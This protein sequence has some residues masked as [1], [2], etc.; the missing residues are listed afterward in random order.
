M[1]SAVDLLSHEKLRKET[2]S[3]L[4][5]TST[6]SLTS[7]S[8]FPSE[9]DHV[10]QEQHQQP[11]YE[12]SE[13][14][15]DVS[16]STPDLVEEE[17]EVPLEYPDECAFQ[18]NPLYFDQS[19]LQQD[20]Q[21]KKFLYRID[22]DEEIIAIQLEKQRALQ[23]ILDI[24][25]SAL[26]S[27][28]PSSSSPS[29]FTASATP[30][31]RDLQNALET[32]YLFRQSAIA[33]YAD[34]EDV[35]EDEH[36]VLLDAIAQATLH[37][38][39]KARERKIDTL[40]YNLHSS[41]DAV[42]SVAN[43]DSLASKTQT[44]TWRRRRAS[45]RI[46]SQDLEDYMD[47]IHMSVSD[48]D[49]LLE[50]MGVAVPPFNNPNGLDQ[51]E[52]PT[53]P[54]TPVTSAAVFSSNEEGENAPALSFSR[55][56]FGLAINTSTPSPVPEIFSALPSAPLTAATSTYS[57]LDD[58]LSDN[59]SLFGL[60]DQK[61]AA[62]RKRHSQHSKGTKALKW[63]GVTPKEEA[64]M[65]R[66]SM[67][68]SI[69]GSMTPIASL[70]RPHLQPERSSM[71]SAIT[72]RSSLKSP[73]VSAFS[74]SDALTYRFDLDDD[75][76]IDELMGGQ[77]HK[78]RSVGKAFKVM[79]IVPDNA[80]ALENVPLPTTPTTP[81]R[82]LS[83]SMGNDSSATPLKALK[84]MGLTPAE[85]LGQAD[86]SLSAAASSHTI[87]KRS[88]LQALKSLVGGKTSNSSLS[89]V[90]D[91]NNSGISIN[92][93]SSSSSSSNGTFRL[94]KRISYNGSH[95]S[96]RSST[97]IRS[98]GSKSAAA[99]SSYTVSAPTV[100][101][102][103]AED[104]Y[105]NNG[106]RAVTE[107]NSDSDDSLFGLKTKPSIRRSNTTQ[108]KAMKVMGISQIPQTAISASTTV[109]SNK[110]TSKRTSS[111]LTNSSGEAAA[112]ISSGRPA[113]LSSMSYDD[114]DA[115]Y[116]N[117]AQSPFQAL[118]FA[119]ANTTEENGPLAGYIQVRS[120]TDAEDRL[121]YFK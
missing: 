52:I 39:S 118:E 97:L 30:T 5:Y 18:E 37:A 106:D 34:Y 50:E 68:P 72:A 64:N 27:A 120:L 43:R 70:N 119:Q 53:E 105:V 47:E 25:A 92:G 113:S 86:R 44:A 45:K 90:D 77:K 73:A 71:H 100:V 101:A 114:Q 4:S 16:A 15:N 66:R 7:S 38:A 14:L 85:M 28:Q 35:L 60:D 24:H 74:E 108:S 65:L 61:V 59:D 6:S 21:A 107:S 10:E 75:L 111:P 11:E 57:T 29:S 121:E 79:G 48:M 81:N 46:S 62:R 31:L 69:S 55:A 91:G 88:S 112:T 42:V 23:E 82:P 8:V 26:S 98:M 110:R 96:Y 102:A 87:N 32:I 67:L 78:R 49:V 115:V 13:D 58:D 56:G 19:D 99:A 40:I 117:R 103:A 22:D 93:G 2:T 36:L 84:V 1:D 109:P 9:N 89:S 12:T 116:A 54:A 63:M 33:E 3:S 94:S 17:D 80:S 83:V 95:Q 76:D 41:T 20:Q 104:Y 51:N